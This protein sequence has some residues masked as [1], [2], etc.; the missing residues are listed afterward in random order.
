MKN[1][2]I[3]HIEN[4][5]RKRHLEEASKYGAHLILLMEHPTWELEYVD[6]FISAD[7]KDIESTLKVV[8]RLKKE[9]SIDGV[10]TFVEH[11]IPVAAAVAQELKVPFISEST[12]FACRNKYEMRNKYISGKILCPKYQLV[13]NIDEAIEFSKLSGFPVV[14]K[15]MI[16]GGSLSV[17]KIASLDELKNRFYKIKT[18]AITTFQ[19]DA[20]SKKTI[21]KYGNKI[22]IEEYIKG[23]EISVES[24]VFS[25]QT[26]VLAIHDKEM[27]SNNK[28][29]P[30]I[31][32][33]TPSQLPENLKE[34][35]IQITKKSNQVLGINCGATHTEYR[36]TANEEIYIIETGARIGGGPIFQSVLS[37]SNI[38][39]IHKIMDISLG[40]DP[41]IG[42]IQQIPVA[43]YQYFINK[44]GVIKNIHP[45]KLKVIENDKNLIELDIYHK[46]GDITAAKRC[47]LAHAHLII[48]GE[49]L[50]DTI[51]RLKDLSG[52]INFDVDE[53]V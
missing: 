10:V 5:S 22:L 16:G 30:E 50:Q 24:L 37:S 21:K 35:I 38:N 48:S 47:T 45:E 53:T 18:S 43:F 42:T 17:E 8:Q 49:T 1:V 31:F 46:N 27:D 2:L 6:E 14:L 51:K 4:P 19:N 7:T 40:I 20:I 9:K 12:A 26:T 11:A 33:S 23:M 36:I 13:E 3:V 29:F 44:S 25:E 15:P 52:Y 41:R 32:F 28:Y 39:M 34:T